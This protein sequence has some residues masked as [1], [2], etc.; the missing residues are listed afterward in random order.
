MSIAL[1]AAVAIG[2]AADTWGAH[3]ASL[4]QFDPAEVA[5]IE[6][7]MWRSYYDGQRL[8]LFTQ[9]A[10]LLRRQYHVPLLRSYVA[11]FQA[12]KAA[13]IFKDG[14]NIDDYKR[15]LPDLTDYYAA[16]RHSGDTFFDSERAARLDLEWWIV[17]R[18]PG[19]YRNGKLQAALSALPAE[20]YQIP[21]GLFTEHARYRAEAM[22]LRDNLSEQNAMTESDWQHINQL[23]LQSWQSLWEAVQN[24]RTAGPA[25]EF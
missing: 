25:S 13:F 15:A 6:T 5:R 23:L 19:S 7:Q 24:S 12:A 22:V 10:G 14:K 21:A 9:L 1:L 16:I 2:W 4:R 20:I 3:S 17:H 18:E 11:A 8:A